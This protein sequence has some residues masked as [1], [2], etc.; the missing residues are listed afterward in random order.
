[1]RWFDVLPHTLPIEFV[2]W[3]CDLLQDS[4]IFHH[5]ERSVAGGVG[6][7]IKSDVDVEGV[8]HLRFILHESDDIRVLTW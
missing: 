8:G 3:S 2:V 7:F 1:M 6:A 5:A 4:T